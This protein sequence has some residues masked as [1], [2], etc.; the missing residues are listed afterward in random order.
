M[1]GSVPR[2]LL[3]F[4]MAR[5]EGSRNCRTC[6]SERRERFTRIQTRI[7]AVAAAT[8]VPRK[9]TASLFSSFRRSSKAPKKL[10]AIM[11]VMAATIEIPNHRMGTIPVRTH[12]RL[13]TAPATIPARVP[14]QLTPPSVPAGTTSPV[15]I[16]RAFALRAW[17]SSLETVSA[18][19]SDSAAETARRKTAL[20]ALTAD[21]PAQPAATARFARTCKAVLPSSF[22]AVPNFSFR[23]YPKRVQIQVR[24]NTETKA[25]NAPNPAPKYRR[26]QTTAPATAPP[27]LTPRTH[28]ARLANTTVTIRTVHSGRIGP[29]TATAAAAR[30]RSHTGK[31]SLIRLLECR[32]RRR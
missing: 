15:V 14:T 6:P 5:T 17:P 19:A 18:A 3:R 12:T 28:R 32:C 2:V 30:V 8:K 26:K 1:R 4:S 20:L 29:S 25:A 13:T 9:F 31:F 21:N 10:S 11:P 22:S 7:E 24:P 27:K 16:S 23:R